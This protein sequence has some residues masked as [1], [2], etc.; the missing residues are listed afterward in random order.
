MVC[1]LPEVEVEREAGGAAGCGGSPWWSSLFLS[2]YR[3]NET[4]FANPFRP[5]FVFDPTKKKTQVI[6]DDGDDTSI[7]IVENIEN[8]LR[9]FEVAEGVEN[10]L[11]VLKN[12]KKK[13]EVTKIISIRAC[14]RRIGVRFIPIAEYGAELR[15][16]SRKGKKPKK[17]ARLLYSR[18]NHYDLLPRYDDVDLITIREN[19][20]GEYSGLEHQVVR[21]VVE[22]LKIIT[23]QA[24]LRVAA[25][26]FHYAKAHWK[27]RVS[28]Q[29]QLHAKKLMVF[30]LSGHWQLLNDACE[31]SSSLRCS[32]DA[33]GP[34]LYGSAPSCNIGEGGIALAKVVLC[35]W[36]ST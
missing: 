22:S 11:I 36:F 17:V 1:S 27:D 28:P 32:G 9:K 29:S 14:K 6:Q 10:T 33:Q 26:A 19:T 15:K 20:E 30:F 25:Y 23:R 16:S 13:P 12:K 34:N 2:L 24:G 21:V 18:K 4:G 31:E 8:L 7:E 35:T 3:L 5:N